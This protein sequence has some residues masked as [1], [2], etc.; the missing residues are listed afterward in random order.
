MKLRWMVLAILLALTAASIVHDGEAPELSDL[1][2]NHLHHEKIEGWLLAFSLIL[3]ALP[4]RVRVTCEIC[5]FEATIAGPEDSGKDADALMDEHERYHR[6][7]G[8][9]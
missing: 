3:V 6:E 1:L 8:E 4:M 7:R 9:I 2:D 5:G